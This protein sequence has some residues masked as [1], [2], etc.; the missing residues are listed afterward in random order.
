MAFHF[1]EDQTVG[2][3]RIVTN[4]YECSS[5]WGREEGDSGRAWTEF[6]VDYFGYLYCNT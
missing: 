5:D 1:R 3:V 6:K 4:S 2:D